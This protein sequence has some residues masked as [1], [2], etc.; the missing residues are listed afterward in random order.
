[1]KKNNH[2]R[3][4]IQMHIQMKNIVITILVILLLKNST[5]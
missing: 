1:M 3:I 5:E 2:R 4:K